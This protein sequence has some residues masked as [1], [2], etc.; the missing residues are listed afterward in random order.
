MRIQHARLP[1]GSYRFTI[2]VELKK[3]VGPINHLWAHK[4]WQKLDIGSLPDALSVETALH[5]PASISNLASRMPVLEHVQQQQRAAETCADLMEQIEDLNFNELSDHVVEQLS[6]A[7]CDYTRVSVHAKHLFVKAAANHAR[8]GGSENAPPSYVS[9]AAALAA[10]LS[11][12]TVVVAGTCNSDKGTSDEGQSQVS[13]VC[14]W[15]T[16]SATHP[17]NSATPTS[18]IVQQGA[19]RGH[20]A[21]DDFTVGGTMPLSSHNACSEDI[22]ERLRQEKD[23]SSYR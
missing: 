15:K 4:V 22:K 21:G 14:C 20:S 1:D 9:V 2:L 5:T 16:C 8:D 18:R 13:M 7:I 11:A 17:S 19:S 6:Q 3:R 12:A 10:A 23:F